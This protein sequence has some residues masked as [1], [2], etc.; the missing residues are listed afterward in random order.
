MTLR[1][2]VARSAQD[3]V[4]V[5]TSKILRPE[6]V[7]QAL[8]LPLP[9]VPSVVDATDLLA[10]IRGED[11]P[12]PPGLVLEHIEH[13]GRRDHDFLGVFCFGAQNADGPFR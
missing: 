5:T 7:W 9:E 2:F 6:R 13:S 3:E 8:L 12:R 11:P 4:A 1:S 10:H